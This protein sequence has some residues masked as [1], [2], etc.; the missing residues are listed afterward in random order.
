MSKSQAKLYLEPLK[1]RQR[2]ERKDVASLVTGKHHIGLD[3]DQFFCETQK[4]W[5]IWQESPTQL[6]RM[7]KRIPRKT[8]YWVIPKES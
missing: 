7:V 1:P 4:A 6:L 5:E 8:V 2:R 3:T